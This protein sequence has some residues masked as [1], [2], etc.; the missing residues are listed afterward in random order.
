MKTDDYEA[1]EKMLGLIDLKNEKIVQVI[2]YSQTLA[3]RDH[4]SICSHNETSTFFLS[5]RLV[6]FAIFPT[7]T[8]PKFVGKA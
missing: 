1:E 3:I 6:T 8:T 5:H 7:A 4:T 2:T